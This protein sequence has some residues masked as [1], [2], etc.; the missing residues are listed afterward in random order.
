MAGI[1]K[2]IFKTGMYFL[3]VFF[4][5]ACHN[6]DTGVADKNGELYLQEG[7]SL[8]AIAQRILV[9]NVMQ[10]IQTEGIAG[11]VSFCNERAI[12]LTD[13]VAA[14]VQAGIARVSD[15]NRNSANAIQTPGDSLAWQKLKAIITDTLA[16]KKHLVMKDS[17]NNMYYYKAIIIAM[18][19]CLNCHGSKEV[20]IA[21]DALVVI[22]QHY[23]ADK[24]TG[25]KIGEFRGMWKIKMNNT[26]E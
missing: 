22:N 13:S 15:K 8:T 18:P 6:A 9:S 26:N 2:I 11:A 14:V 12:P 1:V 23:P 21:P 25:Y 19:A 5:I 10:A 7:D 17:D 16:V 3:T 4:V 20:D 24:A